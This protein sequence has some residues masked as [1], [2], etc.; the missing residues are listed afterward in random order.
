MKYIY[1][2]G[3]PCSGKGTISNYLSDEFGFYHVRTSKILQQHLLDNYGPNSSKMEEF[4]NG[5][6]TNQ[7][8]VCIVLKKILQKLD[9]NLNTIIDGFPRSI[10]QWEEH[11]SFCPNIKKKIIFLKTDDSVCIERMKKRI[12]CTIC[13]RE[14]IQ[15]EANICSFCLNKDCLI[16]RIDDKEDV[17]KTRLKVFNEN[18]EQL[19]HL[20]YPNN[21]TTHFFDTNGDI[22]TIFN[23]IKNT[24][25]T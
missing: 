21:V 19:Y 22:Q 6:L 9:Q 18:T 14:Q 13:Y 7:Q 20:V 1:I 25:N 10:K 16:R 15:Q 17:F 8:E 23:N 5:N 12:V 24:F 4:K 2:I 3:K 11:S